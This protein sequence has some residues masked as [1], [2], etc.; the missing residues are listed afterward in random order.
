ME[1]VPHFKKKVQIHRI[2]YNEIDAAKA[3]NIRAL[4]VF[5]RV[6]TIKRNII[7]KNYLGG[8]TKWQRKYKL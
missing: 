7:Y 3:Y 6:R 2:L 1:S 4:D 8:N 5:W